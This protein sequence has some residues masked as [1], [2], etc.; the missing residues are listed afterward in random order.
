MA[1]TWSRQREA[2]RERAESAIKA[3][4]VERELMKQ[5]RAERVKLEEE[6]RAGLGSDHARRRAVLMDQLMQ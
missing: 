5:E 4:A 1:V 3:M 6:E 2:K